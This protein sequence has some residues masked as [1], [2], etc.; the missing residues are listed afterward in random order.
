MVVTIFIFHGPL[1]TCIV[2]CAFAGSDPLHE[3]I[4]SALV[5]A[6]KVGSSLVGW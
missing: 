4:E 1:D 3:S 6:S 2:E 5:P